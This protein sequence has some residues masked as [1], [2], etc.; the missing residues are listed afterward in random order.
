MYL[1]QE[2]IEIIKE[3]LQTKPVFK[4]YLLG[5]YVRGDASITSDIDLLLEFDNSQRIGLQFIRIK[6]D[7]EFLLNKNIDL[8]TSQGISPRMKV[9]IEKEKKLIYA[10]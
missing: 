9:D 10:K 2:K 8:V 1:E 6:H 7:L 5:S 4:A 3:Y